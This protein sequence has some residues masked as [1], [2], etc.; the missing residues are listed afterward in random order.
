MNSVTAELRIMSS[1]EKC[2]PDE[3]LSK[4]PSMAHFQMLPNQ[5]L[6]FEI[7]VCRHGGT[8]VKDRYRLALSGDLAPYASLRVVTL[9]PSM[10]ACEPN[11]G[12]EF[13]RRDSQGLY[14]DLLRPL[15]YH[16]EFWLLSEQPQCFFVDIQPKDTLLPGEHSVTVELIHTESAEVV[17]RETVSVTLKDFAL[18]PQTMPH[19]EWFYTDCIAT[20]HR[21]K[22]FSEKHW[23]LIEQY[24]RMAVEN[25]INMILTPVFTPELDTYI[26][27][28]R[29]TTQL[30]G[31][32]VEKDGSYTFD[33]TWMDRWF[34]LCAKVG[35]TYYEI[36]HFFTQWGAK[37][38][39]KIIAK[40][41]GR[42]KRI[43]GW[44]TDARGES[45]KVFLREMIPA[46]VA[47]L[48][49]RGVAD[50]TYFHISDEPRT[51]ALDQYLAC[52][53]MVAPYLKD[54][55][56]IDALSHYEFYETGALKKPVAA[57]YRIEPF[58]E[59]KV[60]GL[61]AYYCGIAA[62]C[63]S[64]MLAMP[65][66]RTRVIG[67]QLYLY[68]IEGFLHW[69][70][71]FYHNQGS[72]DALDPLLYT[73]GEWFNASG[74]TALVWPGEPDT[75]CGSLR[76]NAMREAMEDVRLLTLAESHLGREAVETC[77]RELAG[78]DI[79]FKKYPTDPAFL[80]TLRHRLIEKIETVR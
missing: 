29:P 36:P 50:K 65:L 15:H 11:A 3:P 61:W 51:E 56:I 52:K 68:R 1:L 46:L 37:H 79:T 32:T 59:H 20:A 38:A 45:Y 58:L 60:P 49:R 44:E 27:G 33:F 17:A 62:E 48:E 24:L 74:D 69:G 22:V 72:Y 54:Y 28:E 43:F 19:T 67:V 78:Y 2:F 77:I 21:V 34:D 31:V 80:L 13:L 16:G 64:R 42:K 4:H 30:L 9:L 76:L 23:D 7:G 41:N 5:P 70:Y 35:V 26:G 55:P 63:S 40:V 47:Y 18:P 12:G 8:R 75:V 57:I 53:A 73:D 39:P 66:S 14:P 25:G 6:A 71:N 10:Y